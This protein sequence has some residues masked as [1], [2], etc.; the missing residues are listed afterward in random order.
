[1]IVLVHS[2]KIKSIV[3]KESQIIIYVLLLILLLLRLL[4]YIIVLICIIV[5]LRI[6]KDIAIVMLNSHSS[7][8]GMWIYLLM[9]IKTWMKITIPLQIIEI[10]IDIVHWTLNL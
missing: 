8:S 10:I 9:H 4:M 1:M 5:L 3:I 7:S 2:F 6:V